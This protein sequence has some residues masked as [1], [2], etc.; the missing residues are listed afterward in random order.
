MC[1]VQDGGS[2]QTH[3]LTGSPP[4][5]LLL[6]LTP[7]PSTMLPNDLEAQET[8]PQVCFPRS[9]GYRKCGLPHVGTTAEASQAVFLTPGFSAC[10]S[11]GKSCLLSISMPSYSS[12]PTFLCFKA[13]CSRHLPHISLFRKL[14]HLCLPQLQQEPA[15]SHANHP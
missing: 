7:A 9:Q 15:R 4:P 11:Y 2:S 5:T 1:L 12:F 10:F 14:L 6:C 13:Q 3:P 8:V